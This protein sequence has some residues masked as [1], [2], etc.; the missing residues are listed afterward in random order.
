MK[1]SNISAMFDSVAKLTRIGIP[2]GY[3]GDEFWSSWQS[4]A[5]GSWEP[6]F[7][8]GQLARGEF[9]V[10]AFNWTYYYDEQGE[11]KWHRTIDYVNRAISAVRKFRLQKLKYAKRATLWG[12]VGLSGN[13]WFPDEPRDSGR[14]LF[15]SGNRLLRL[16]DMTITGDEATID[17]STLSGRAESLLASIGYTPSRRSEEE[18]YTEWGTMGVVRYLLE[19]ELRDRTRW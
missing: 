17:L 4:S 2:H 5:S 13:K 10:Q 15:V 11:I 18:A 6:G 8:P 9:Y 12:V 16:G 1:R 3:W 14:N 7:E 19:L